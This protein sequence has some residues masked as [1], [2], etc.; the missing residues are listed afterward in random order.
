MNR[1]VYDSLTPAQQKIYEIAAG[2]AHQ[3]NL[4]QFLSN[5]SSALTRLQAGGVKTL[6][7]PG[8]GLGCVRQSIR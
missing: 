1:E 3:W 7:I 8:Y 2:E 6:A 4:A 5:N